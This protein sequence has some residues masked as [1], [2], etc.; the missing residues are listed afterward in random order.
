LENEAGKANGRDDMILQD[1]VAIVTGA[2]RGIGRAIALRFAHEGARVVVNDLNLSRAQEV[3]KE[4]KDAGSDATA[5]K[6][7]V[8]VNRVAESLASAAVRKFGRIDILVNN[9]G[10]LK[11]APVIK[12]KEEDWDRTFDVNV[13]G[14]FLCSRAVAR[15]MVRQRSGKIIN[16]ASIAGKIPIL[17]ESAYCASK[18]AVIHFTRA[19]ATEL[20]P[21]KVNVN[22]ICPG[23]TDTYLFNDTIC[24]RNKSVLMKKVSGIPLGRIATP[25]D[26]AEAVLFLASPPSSHIT[27]QVLN[28]DGGQ[29]MY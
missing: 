22:A 3:V 21:Y 2:A 6:G 25:E 1:K 27:G 5:V 16:N 12:M 23:C 7:D 15:Y 19:L 10:Y 20:A 17:N 11:I 13:K 4:I 26:Q 28:I 24:R 9:A 29:V 8:S 18:A 14:T